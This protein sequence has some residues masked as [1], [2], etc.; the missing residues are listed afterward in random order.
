MS[1]IY[2]L[3]ISFRS[4]ERPWTGSHEPYPKDR[5][6]EDD[7]AAKQWAASMQKQLFDYNVTL[8]KD[9]ILLRW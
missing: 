9:G 6:A 7:E 1:A 4:N 5:F 2:R 3:L 8:L